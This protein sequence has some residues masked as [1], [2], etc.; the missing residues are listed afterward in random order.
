M[1]KQAKLIAYVMVSCLASMA[2][3]DGSLQVRSG[4]EPGGG[5]APGGGTTGGETTGGGEVVEEELV[6]A[7]A[8]PVM[9][10]LTVSEWRHTIDD[11]F[12][13][14]TSAGFEVEPDQRTNGLSAIGSG[15]SSLSPR[16]VEQFEAASLE[17]A[18]AVMRDPVRRGEWVACTPAGEVDDACAEQFVRGAARRL[19][20]RSVTDTEVA[21]YVRVA[22]RS[23]Q[24]LGEFYTGVEF[25]L[26]GM[27]QSPY[28]LYRVEYP[29][30]DIRAESV[31]VAP[32]ATRLEAETLE[33]TS[34]IVADDF[35][36]V[37]SEGEVF[38]S[39]EITRPGVY[40]VRSRACGQLAGPDLPIMDLNVNGA[41]VGTYSVSQTCDAPRVFEETVTLEAGSVRV[42]VAFGNDFFDQA[43]GQDRN[44]F[45]DWIEVEG[46]IGAF[47]EVDGGATLTGCEARDGAQVC[48]IDAFGLATRISFLLWGSTPDEELLAAAESGEL[49]TPE[50]VRAQVDRMLEDARS[51]RGFAQFWL[52]TWD[53]AEL[54]KIDK[55]QS[56]YPEFTPELVESMQGE[57]VRLMNYLAFDAGADMRGMFTTTTTFV[58]ARLASFYGVEMSD[59]MDAQG[60][61]RITLPASTGRAGVLTH[62]GVLS[63]HTHSNTGST[64]RRGKFVRQKLLCESVNDAPPGV[65]TV[66]PDPPPES[67]DQTHR[68]RVES[69]LFAEAFCASCHVKMDPL[70]YAYENFGTI[71]QWRELDNG[72]PIDTSSQLDGLAYEG[73]GGLGAL[74]AEDRRAMECF[75]RKFYRHAVGRL[76]GDGEEATIEGLMKDFEAGGWR[77]DALL[78]SLVTSEGFTKMTPP[79]EGDAGAGE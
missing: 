58:D 36:N 69:Y 65:S 18:A 47:D 71:G 24:A 66:F 62:A 4:G 20:R 49:S 6:F 21:R 44:L 33:A 30:V 68:E 14:G 55:D 15:Q 8:R 37:W 23:S 34:G 26:A 50:G 40:R 10:R 52:E 5:N 60:F 19:W 31:A 64:T 48:T 25:A 41:S 53:L 70:G 46:P 35:Y 7:P 17:I 45:V 12:G 27:L 51:K 32:S 2:A 75:T 59:V 22:S 11:L 72:R 54:D 77:F 13:A 1:S 29:A 28:F 74:L 63:S 79:V 39:F 78:A 3:C 67:E 61:S 76:E 57:T 73:A 42:A 38:G 9:R 43:S 56:L 16:G